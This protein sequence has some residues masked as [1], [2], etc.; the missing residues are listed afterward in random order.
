[1]T[2]DAWRYVLL[3]DGRDI[4]LTDGEVTLGRSRTS[5]VRVDH[6]SVSRS[7]ALL[8]F[9]RGHAVLKDLNSSN[10]TYVG[11]RRVLNETTLADGDRIQL[12]AA[13]IGFRMLAP[14]GPTERTTLME[15]EEAALRPTAPP[16][17][18]APVPAETGA[19][20]STAPEPPPPHPME[21]SAEELLGSGG[22]P[23]EPV[24]AAS[25]LEAL[26]SSGESPAISAPPPP[27]PAPPL[28]SEPPAPRPP[29]PKPEATLSQFSIRPGSE[30]EAYQA[31]YPAPAALPPGAAR[32]GPAGSGLAPRLPEPKNVAGFFPRLLALCVDHVILLAIN[33]LL[34][35]PVFLILFFRGVV[36]P[37]ES[38][39]DWALVGVSGLCV[40]LMVAADIWYVVGGWARN[41]R[42]PGKSLLGLAIVS[43]R[44]PGPGLGWGV[45]FARAL[46]TIVSSLPLGLGYLVVLFRK[47]RRAWH[48]LLA[49][50]WVVKIR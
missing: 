13:L 7:H 2:R 45:A 1:M 15:P 3:V 49:G 33:L 27:P 12:G 42:T 5:T 36:Q 25:A 19:I 40:V 26:K 34:M 31:G 37:R 14:I 35:S 50:T 21:I 6:E 44:S 28:R 41:G 17:V 29:A 22:K 39:P 32:V 47:D 23:A 8:T 10:G 4:E 9:D 38:G 11:G 30:P 16:G 20:S 43:D 24:A 18:P 48:D 46:Y